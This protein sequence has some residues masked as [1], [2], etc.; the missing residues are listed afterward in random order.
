MDIGAWL[1]AFGLERYEPAF[2]DND[3]DAE[4]L[5]ELTPEDSTAQ[6]SRP[7]KGR[8]RSLVPSGGS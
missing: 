4:V 8:P 2:R 1:R 5:F 6:P 7:A 3:I